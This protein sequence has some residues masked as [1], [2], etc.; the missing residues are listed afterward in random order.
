MEHYF[1]FVLLMWQVALRKSRWVSSGFPQSA[2]VTL[3][4]IVKESCEVERPAT[5]DVTRIR[6][7]K[8]KQVKEKA[9]SLVLALAHANLLWIVW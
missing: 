6:D 3:T 2:F 9:N 8:Q 1:T 7:G 4:I 5:C